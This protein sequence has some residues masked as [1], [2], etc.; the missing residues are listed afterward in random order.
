MLLATSHYPMEHEAYGLLVFVSHG[1]VLSFFG[2]ELLL[3]LFGFGLANCLSDA[4]IVFDAFIVVS[5][6]AC[7]LMGFSAAIELFR[8]FRLAMLSDALRGLIVAVATCLKRSTDILLV[9][10]LIIYFYA[11]VG[12]QT[13]GVA[14]LGCGPE[15]LGNPEED[16]CYTNFAS[17]PNAVATLIQIALGMEYSVILGQLAVDKIVDHN[18]L[19][20]FM[21]FSS[22]YFLSSFVCINLFI[23][24][25][26][27][28]FGSLADVE[29]DIDFN[30]FWGFAYAWADLTVG[31]HACPSLRRADAAEFVRSLRDIVAEVR[32]YYSRR[33]FMCIFLIG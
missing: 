21:Y 17:F 7:K 22:Y 13:Y 16:Q 30:E 28:N 24:S 8:I 2:L 1:L 14:N 23:V 6:G 12:M 26:L 31:A 27:D 11:I 18:L 29:Q 5:A 3:R 32:A 10:G 4:G 15:P 33:H 25:I 9:S 19:L 20:A